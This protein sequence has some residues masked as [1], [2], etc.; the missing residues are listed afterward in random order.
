MSQST[1]YSEQDIMSETL[2]T[3]KHLKSEFNLLTQEAG[4]PE[5]YDAAKKLYDG[6]ST[7]QRDVYDSMVA[8][9]WYLPT[10]EKAPVIAKLYTKFSKKNK[11]L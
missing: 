11:D 10:S 2:N 4:T 6:I 9:G 7:I 5:L 8:Q 3:I 1:K